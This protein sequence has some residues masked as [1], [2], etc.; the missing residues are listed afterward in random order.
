M[1][2]LLS[3]CQLEVSLKF[4]EQPLPAL[5][6]NLS[7]RATLTETQTLSH[8]HRHISGDLSDKHS[9]VNQ[10]C[11]FSPW[12]P[13]GRR[14]KQFLKLDMQWVKQK[15]K[16]EERKEGLINY[17]D[18][19]KTLR[20]NRKSPWEVC[21]SNVPKRLGKKTNMYFPEEWLLYPRGTKVSSVCMKKIKKN[22]KKVFLYFAYHVNLP[23]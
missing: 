4:S 20:E 23:F 7:Q 10:L 8:I 2:I 6:F 11:T 18:L 5:R 13:S 21:K 3:R 1:H 16:N 22:I 9:T 19:E 15:A 17:W 14:E 12:L